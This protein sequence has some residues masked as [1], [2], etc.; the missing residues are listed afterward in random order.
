MPCYFCQ[1]LPKW[2]IHAPIK[3]IPNLVI[4]SSFFK[5]LLKLDFFI[6]FFKRPLFP[7]YRQNV[8]CT[9]VFDIYGGEFRHLATL[10]RRTLGVQ[11]PCSV[12]RKYGW[13]GPNTS[14]LV[15]ELRLILESSGSHTHY[16]INQILCLCYLMFPLFCKTGFYFR[17]SAVARPDRAVCVPASGPARPLPVYRRQEPLRRVLRL[18][19]KGRRVSRALSLL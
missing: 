10:L 8:F 9:L 6:F 14:L 15:Y 16:H 11:W 19:G 7:V 17:V 3:N 1:I 5:L 2:K 13:Q 18:P 12:P 4:G